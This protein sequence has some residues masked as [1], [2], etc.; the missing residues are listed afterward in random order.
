MTDQWR[1]SDDLI[2]V[3]YQQ[4][5]GGINNN[6]NNKPCY[7]IPVSPPGLNVLHALP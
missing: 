3:G 6:Q 5:V 7:K 4:V 1:F 2:I